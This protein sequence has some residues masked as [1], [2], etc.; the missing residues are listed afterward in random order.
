MFV[1]RDSGHVFTLKWRSSV[2]GSPE[3]G[4]LHLIINSFKCHRYSFCGTFAERNKLLARKHML[5]NI[6]RQRKNYYNPSS[7]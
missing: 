1:E 6:H 2:A 7:W 4:K 3:I 5:M